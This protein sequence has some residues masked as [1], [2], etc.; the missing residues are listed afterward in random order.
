[1]NPATAT[2]QLRQV[3]R[4]P[5]AAQIAFWRNKLRNLVPTSRWDDLWEDQ[6]DRGFMIAG[7][8]TADLLTDFAAAVD[9]A[10]VDGTSLADFRR[11]FDSIVGKHGWQYTGERNWRTRVI[12]RTNTATSYAAGRMAQLREFPFWMY[13]HGG[14]AD[15][16]PQH[17]AWDGLVLPSDHPFWSTHAPPNG[18][19]CSCRIIGLR[20]REDARALGG[21][22]DK[23]LPA[24]WDAIDARTGAPIG[25]DKGWAYQP[26]ASVVDLVEQMAGKMA[27]WDKRL[28]T[29]FLD[30]MPTALRKR[31]AQ[32]Y[33]TGDAP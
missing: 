11:D 16:R 14:S 30:G 15:P 12:Y 29:A 26:G 8:Q 18:W 24:D 22:P 27:Q 19:G 5:F 10:I 23:A 21:D 28:A 7:A 3:F 32:A 2:P 33:A 13:R 4:E 6:H 31:L 1:M 17:L 25:I 20:R 9:K